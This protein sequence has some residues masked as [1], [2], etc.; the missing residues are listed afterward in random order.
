MIYKTT[1][2][3]MGFN[4]PYIKSVDTHW[5]IQHNHY[6]FYI[7]PFAGW[8]FQT[9]HHSNLVIDE[10][11]NKVK[12]ELHLIFYLNVKSWNQIYENLPPF[13]NMAVKF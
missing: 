4:F 13:P 8:S 7:L 9:G 11:Y 1:Q 6:V 5:Y 2:Q 10:I 3:I 12:K